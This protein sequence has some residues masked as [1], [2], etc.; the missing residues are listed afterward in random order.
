MACWSGTC[1]PCGCVCGIPKVAVAELVPKNPVEGAVEAPKKLLPPVE[2]A[3]VWE[4]NEKPP[5]GAG[6]WVLNENPPVVGVAVPA[7]PAVE[8]DPKAKEGAGVEEAKVEAGFV[9]VAAVDPKGKDGV[10]AEKGAGAGVVVA[11]LP[12]ALAGAVDE[13]VVV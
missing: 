1:G 10:E 13:N 4:L 3:G 11:A 6:V 5:E 12:T 8:V 2:D 9:F 7:A